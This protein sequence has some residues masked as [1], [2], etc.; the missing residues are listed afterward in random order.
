MSWLSVAG[1]LITLAGAFGY[2]NHRFLKLPPTVAMTGMSLVLVLSLAA[3][4]ATGLH[5][6]EPVAE[7][8]ARIDFPALLLD[9]MLALLLFAAALHVNFNDLAENKWSI[10]TFATVGVIGSTFL[11]GGMVW[12]LSQLMDLK[13]EPI[14][15]ILFGALI[16]PTDPI[17]VLAVFRRLGAVKS[18]ETRI[19]G[20]SLFND[21]I[22]VVVFL[23]VLSVARGGGEASFTSVATLFVKE[24]IGGLALG[25]IAGW[26]AYRALK[27]I[28]NYKVEVLITLALVV[29]SYALAGALH[30][31]GPLAVVA[32]GLLIG[33]EGRRL[34]MSQRTREHLDLFWELIDE[35]LNSVLFV[36]IGL[37]ALVVSP[38]GVLLLAGAAAIPIILLSR[39]ISIGIPVALLRLVRPFARRAV[40]ILIWGGLRGGISV[41][42]VL[43]VPG[44][45]P[46]WAA[47]REVL[48]T[49]TYLVVIFS[50]LV[51]GLTIKKLV[52]GA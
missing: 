7:M 31:S 35:I 24:A 9:G 20:E 32:A 50:I 6:E 30:V 48:L 37:E 14:H 41:A 19:A 38:R 5:L 34:G 36:L 23:T 17:A 51:Q 44:D 21:G 39:A 10:A 46:L 4:R 52:R 45:T 43:S 22:G 16:S 28:D 11:V 25:L 12:G 49:M 3:G 15:C 40:R 18:L 13:L 8:L 47:A 27:S 26:I 2:V 29:G 33:N 1:I 42:L